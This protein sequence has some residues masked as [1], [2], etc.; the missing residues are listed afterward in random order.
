[1]R[2]QKIKTGFTALGTTM[3]LLGAV[4]SWA[5]EEPPTV[6][7]IAIQA[8]STPDQHAALA[9]YYRGKA[10][11]ARKEARTH[12]SMRHGYAANVSPR[13]GMDTHCNQLKKN[14]E[15]DAAAYDAMAAE[16]DQMAKGAK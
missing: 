2:N 5:A 8:A 15:S 11:E 10:E 13:V 12:I 3:L 6:Q 7:S 9:S 1:M 14:A 16:H 4:S